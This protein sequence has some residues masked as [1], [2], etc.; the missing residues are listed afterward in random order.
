MVDRIEQIHAKDKTDLFRDPERAACGKIR[1]HQIETTKSISSQISLRR[2]GGHN[3]S[4]RIE[5]PPS[6]NVGIV[7]PLRNSRNQVWP[8]SIGPETYVAPGCNVDGERGL[9]CDNTVP[10]PAA[11][12]RSDP[13]R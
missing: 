9:R 11:R 13:K 2:G 10:T 4:R 6:G 12:Q 7:G 5:L 3:K 8:E 1:L